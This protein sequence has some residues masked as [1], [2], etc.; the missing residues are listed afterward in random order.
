[1]HNLEEVFVFLQRIFGEEISKVFRDHTKD[2][3][4]YSKALAFTDLRSS[5]EDIEKKLKDV[6]QGVMVEAIGM[7]LNANHSKKGTVDIVVGPDGVY[8]KDMNEITALR[9]LSLK[10]EEITTVMVS[11]WMSVFSRGRKLANKIV[12]R[13]S[14]YVRRHAAS[15]Y[16][17]S[18]KDA[19]WS[20]QARDYSA[21]PPREALDIEI[22][23]LEA[24]LP[25]ITEEDGK[26]LSE[27][28]AMCDSR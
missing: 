22:M 27:L 9:E 28:Y 2:V 12:D 24:R 6:S 16:E 17:A 5:D 14:K 4:Y 10:H 13:D 1:M 19:N 18:P 21:N 8:D 25:N 11:S 26:R 3:F 20:A 15:M 7:Y 23:R